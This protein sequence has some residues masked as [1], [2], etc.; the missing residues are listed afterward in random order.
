VTHAHA[1]MGKQQAAAWDGP[2]D[3]AGAVACWV[4]DD[5]SA[6]GDGN[7][8]A[9]WVDRIGGK[10]LTHPTAARRP[11]YRAV[12]NLG[13][14]PALDF[15]GSNDILYYTA[16]DAISTALSGHVFIVIRGDQLENRSP[17]GTFDV[18]SS[19]TGGFYLAGVATNR[20]RLAHEVQTGT[21]DEVRVAASNSI[22]T[23]TDYLWEVSSDGS[24][25]QIRQNGAVQTL[26]VE[27]GSNTGDWFGDSP[28]R[29]NFVVGGQK[30]NAAVDTHEFSVWDGRIA[31]V[32]VVDGPISAG[33]RTALHAWVAAKYGITIA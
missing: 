2:E 7:P 19:F 25:W 23:N 16:A 20:L 32:L 3:V 6:V 24:A 10:T 26:A 1:V 28:N 4:A 21:D 29:D 33:D 17:W 5:C 9:N 31:M 18:G 12:S 11:L 30:Y 14:Q 22:A 27:I 13:S 8:V 15:D